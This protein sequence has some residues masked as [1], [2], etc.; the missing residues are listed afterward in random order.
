MSF[1]CFHILIMI[2]FFISDDLADSSTYSKSAT[3]SPAMS[4][5]DGRGGRGLPHGVQAAKEVLRDFRESSV[6]SRSSTGSASV[7]GMDN[8]TN[9][10][11]QDAEFYDVDAVTSATRDQKSPERYPS[12]Y[13]NRQ[14]HHGSMSSLGVRWTFYGIKSKFFLNVFLPFR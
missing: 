1:L 11:S 13:N 10:N 7:V 14:H 12:P 8:N 6:N 9:I 4:G 5:A 3:P 2:L